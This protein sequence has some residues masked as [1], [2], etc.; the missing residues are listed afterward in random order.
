MKSLVYWTRTNKTFSFL[1]MFW[2]VQNY[3]V[4]LTWN[5]TPNKPEIKHC[6]PKMAPGCYCVSVR[7]Y[8]TILA[9]WLLLCNM[10]LGWMSKVVCTISSEW[11]M[12]GLWKI[13][14]LLNISFPYGIKAIIVWLLSCGRFWDYFAKFKVRTKIKKESVFVC[15]VFQTCCFENSHNIDRHVI[16]ILRSTC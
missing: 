16:W 1:H 10:M 6:W 3:S 2:S 13:M 7:Y 15:F 14:L 12:P 4:F 11:F 8:L 5:T 9:L